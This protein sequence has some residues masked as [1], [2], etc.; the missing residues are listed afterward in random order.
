MGW[1]DSMNG[2]DEK[3]KIV[4][5]IYEGKRPLKKPRNRW[6]DNTEIILKK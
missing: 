2:T 1:A 5:R 6:E 3:H 4:V